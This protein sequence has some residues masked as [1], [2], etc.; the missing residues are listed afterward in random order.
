V[1]DSFADGGGIERNERQGTLVERGVPE[2]DIV[3]WRIQP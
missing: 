2:R 1:A 3:Q